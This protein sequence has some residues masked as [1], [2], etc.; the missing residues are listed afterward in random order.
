M[1][2]PAAPHPDAGRRRS[3]CAIWGGATVTVLVLLVVVAQ[4]VVP[5]IASRVVEDELRRYGDV[6]SVSVS[7]FPVWELLSARIDAVEIDMGETRDRPSDGTAAAGP[8]V[9]AAAIDLPQPGAVRD[10]GRELA[11][12]MLRTRKVER[13]DASATRFTTGDVVVQDV[14]ITKR[15][16]RITAAGSISLEDV[17]R[18]LPAA[19]GLTASADGDRL[20]I[21]GQYRLPL[22]VTTTVRARVAVHEG[23]LVL[24]AGLPLNQAFRVPVFAD[25][26][27]TVLGARETPCAPRFCFEIAA[28]LDG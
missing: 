14:R 6:R 5:G 2:L 25:D 22:G 19:L 26:R 18:A 1:S 27:V 4:L 9:R 24:E 8:R 28:R 12:L 3:T 15:G 23:G 17:Q 21:T 20:A 11:D 16:D 10:R 13:V 7:S